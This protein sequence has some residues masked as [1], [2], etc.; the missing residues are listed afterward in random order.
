MFASHYYTGG[1][2]NWYHQEGNSSIIINVA[3]LSDDI[4]DDLVI[5]FDYDIMKITIQYYPNYTLGLKLITETGISNLLKKMN[6]IKHLIITHADNMITGELPDTLETLKCCYDYNDLILTN[7]TRLK[8]VELY[9]YINQ[10]NLASNIPD[11]PDCVDKVR[12]HADF[13]NDS[14][15]RLP[16]SIVELELDLQELTIDLN[17]WPINLQKLQIICRK[18]NEYNISM[19]PPNLQSLVLISNTYSNYLDLPPYLNYIDIGLS[20]TYQHTMIFPD[21]IVNM[22]L[23]YRSFRNIV[24]LPKQCTNFVYL[25]CPDSKFKE[26]CKQQ[27]MKKRTEHHHSVTL[28]KYK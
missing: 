22:K 3:A 5:N 1:V 17:Y 16:S 4:I 28:Q 8:S 25:N 27:R 13:I 20:P 26:L 2:S 9:S 21:T 10:Q 23:D 19:L 7:C 24:N 12:I 18:C 14:F 15:Y 6:G 11:L